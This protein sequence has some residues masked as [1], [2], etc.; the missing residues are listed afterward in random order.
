MKK[1]AS[2][3][4]GPAAGSTSGRWAGAALLLGVVLVAGFLMAGPVASQPERPTPAASG[5]GE[6]R[7]AHADR[8]DA[9]ERADI[10]AMLASNVARLTTEGRLPQPRAADRV[11]LD[12]PLTERDGFTDPGYHAVTGFVDHAAGYPNQLLDYACGGRTYDSSSGYNHQGTDFYLW[13][14]AWNKMAAGDVVVVAAAMVAAAV[15]VVIVT[16]V[17]ATAAPGVIVK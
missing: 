17:V 16:A 9:D 8:I 1:Q 4:D 12:W 5:G 15:V 11:A 14:F 3:G 13:P 10:E 6:Y 7:L 2:S